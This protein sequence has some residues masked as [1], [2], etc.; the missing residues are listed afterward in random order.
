[1]LTQHQ[2]RGL[3]FIIPRRAP[4]ISLTSLRSRLMSLPCCP[5]VSILPSFFFEGSQP[6]MFLLSE[7]S[8][9]LQV[10]VVL[11]SDILQLDHAPIYGG[12]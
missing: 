11:R 2:A 10:S 1:M 9:G 12:S 4:R 6:I 7:G 3:L 8:S 5:C